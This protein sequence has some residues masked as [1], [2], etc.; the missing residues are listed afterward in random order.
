MDHKRIH[1]I[2]WL[3][4]MAVLLLFPFHTWRVYNYNDP[5]YVKSAQTSVG[6]SYVIAFIDRWHMPLLFLLAGMSTYLALGK[7][8]PGRFAS[9]RVRRLLVPFL[10]GLVVLVPP[11]T[12]YGARFNSGYTGSFWEY[13]SSGAFLSVENVARTGTD[14][15]GGLGFAHLWFILYLFLISLLVLPLVAFA[16][17]ERGANTTRRV[18]R[19]L[20]NPLTWIVPALLLWFTEGLPDPLDMS[21]FMYL[22][23]FVLG[24]AIVSDEA[25]AKAAERHRWWALAAG[26]LISGVYVAAAGWRDSIPDPS[27]T[28]MAVNVTGMLG[29][30]CVIVGA[31]GAG[32]RFL[33]R[34]SQALA[35]NAESSYP[36]Y[37]LHQTVIVIIAFYLVQVPLAWPLQWFLLL[38][39]SVAVTFA[40]YEVVRR[41]GSLR[42]LFGMRPKAAPLPVTDGAHPTPASMP[43]G[44]S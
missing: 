16:R 3:R 17:T 30:W 38:G 23:C 39:A 43:R 42:F 29:V 19:F 22:T 36:V 18:A 20:A 28:L 7:R 10:F 21:F 4:V 41:V 5:F 34:P 35:Y 27:W 44:E 13:L 11:Q 37:L 14:Y 32:R 1:Y 24:F 6:L 33:D 9:E 15:Y 8:G 40:L 25:F 26:V 2:D 31:L 12:W